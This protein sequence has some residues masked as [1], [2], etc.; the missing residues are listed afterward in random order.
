V[1]GIGLVLNDVDGFFIID[2][3]VIDVAHDFRRTR[4]YRHTEASICL[5]RQYGYL[6]FGQFLIGFTPYV[7]L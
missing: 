3:C 7:L 5:C 6:Q 2:D 4:L 1:E